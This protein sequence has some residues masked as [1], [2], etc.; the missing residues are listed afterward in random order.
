M[1]PLTAVKGP[2]SRDQELLGELLVPINNKKDGYFT[3][4][5]P[6][7]VFKHLFPAVYVCCHH[8]GAE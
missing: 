4:L 3:S 8:M 1:G 5:S 2:L 7:V 6:N